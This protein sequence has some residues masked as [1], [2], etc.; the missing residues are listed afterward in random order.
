MKRFWLFVLL[1]LPLSVA[2]A[3]SFEE[4][5]QY[6]KLSHPQPT[7]DADKIEVVELFWY[8]CPH[9]HKFQPYVEKWLKT[10]PDNVSYVRMPAILREDWSLHA[11]AFYT[12]EILGALDRIHTP[13]FDAIH[14]DKRHLFTENKL[15]EFFQEHGVSNDDFRNTF[16]SFAVDSKVRRARQM[17]R[18]YQVRG[19]PAVVVNGKYL[20]GPGMA[21]GFDN[22]IKVIDYLVDKESHAS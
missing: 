9:C 10:K 8:G 17:T 22:M 11:R 19:T 3:A 7:V 14:N 2:T 16:H 1:A 20:T 13:L 4:G 12:A 15:M 18:R 5:I 21:N 6:T